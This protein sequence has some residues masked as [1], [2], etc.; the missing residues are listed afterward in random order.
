MPP[1]RPGGKYKG[2]VMRVKGEESLKA[3]AEA[4]RARALEEHIARLEAKK[5]TDKKAAEELAYRERLKQEETRQ[6]IIA[7][8]MGGRKGSTQKFFKAWI[9]GMA[10]VKE[11]KKNLERDNAWRRSCCCTDGPCVGGCAAYLRLRDPG[12]SLPFD[13]AR[14]SA[15]R[16]PLPPLGGHTSG[17]AS[18]GGPLEST[19]LPARGGEAADFRRPVVPQSPP[20]SASI[21]LHGTLRRT[22]S[23]SSLT[24]PTARHIGEEG[25]ARHFSRWGCACSKCRNDAPLPTDWINPDTAQVMVHHR[26]GRR[27]L[28]DPHEYRMCFA[29]VTRHHVLARMPQTVV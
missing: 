26:T 18:S 17:S 6:K 21:D 14:R 29:D 23:L 5:E 28:V 13:A 25:H 27:I 9:K 24:S 11:E 15:G 20:P 3:A 10:V 16:L 8:W 1:R 7:L 19:L 2:T 4:A 12:F 22:A